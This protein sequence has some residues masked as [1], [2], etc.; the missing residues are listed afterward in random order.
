MTHGAGD[1]WLTERRRARRVAQFTE[2]PAAEGVAVSL[3]G[4]AAIPALRTMELA[5]NRGGCSAR[6]STGCQGSAGL[7]VRNR[8]INP[9]V[10]A[11]LRSPAHR[12]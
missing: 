10:R 3:A 1:A 11:L 9:L 7:S 4:L 6:S 12:A 5:R 8:V 2:L